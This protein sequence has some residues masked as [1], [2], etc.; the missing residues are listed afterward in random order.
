MVQY[1]F[2]EKCHKERLSSRLG[3]DDGETGSLCQKNEWGN[4]ITRR[5]MAKIVY[6]ALGMALLL[7]GCGGG[8]QG[9]GENIESAAEGGK[10]DTLLTK[11]SSGNLAEAGKNGTADMQD[12]EETATKNPGSTLGLEN[13]EQISAAPLLETGP[14]NPAGELQDR[15]SGMMVRITAGNLQGSGVILRDDGRE[16]LIVTA[17][18]VLD[19]AEGGADIE[20]RD[21]FRVRTDLY[22]RAEEADLAVLRIPRDSL[23]EMAEDGSVRDHGEDYLCC[24][25]DQ[26]AYDGVRVGDVVIAM[27]SYTGVAEDAYAGTL[28]EDYVYAE[29]FGA[30]MMLAQ[31]PVKAGMSGG[32]LFDEQGR[33]L[34]ILCGVSEDEE[35]AVAPLIAV[36]AML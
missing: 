18:H 12:N 22:Q 13:C 27:G 35:V 7:S 28:T 3:G 2:C 29:D 36:L 6:I 19:Q 11:E 34:G 31:V 32:G 4:R 14:E 17:G 24:P 1:P 5:A 33:L 26:N 21:G 20:F 30:Y 16:L 9:T 15:C 8:M 10:S 25:V 23:L